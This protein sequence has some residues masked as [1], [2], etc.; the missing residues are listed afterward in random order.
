[1]KQSSGPV[2]KP[3]EAVIKDIRRPTR[4]Q[5]SAEEKMIGPHAV[6]QVLS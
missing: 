1:M 3:A 4:R 5:F 2:R 6:V